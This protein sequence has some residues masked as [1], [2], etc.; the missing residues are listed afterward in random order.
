MIQKIKIWFKQTFCDHDM[1]RDTQLTIY[2]CP[3]CGESYL[4]ANDKKLAY[5][6]DNLEAD[7]PLTP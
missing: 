5:K 2:W 7:Y 6:Q 1:H 3:K 4:I